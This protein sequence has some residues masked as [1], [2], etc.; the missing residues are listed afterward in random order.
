MNFDTYGFD[1]YKEQSVRVAVDLVNTWDLIADVDGLTTVEELE[2]F[3]TRH[4]GAWKGS[5]LTF[6]QP[7]ARDL[8]A[9]RR[10]REEIR[11]VFG[12]DN[13]DKA[14]TLINAILAN[15]GA[16]PRIGI[17]AKAPHLYF[18]TRSENLAHQLAAT[19]ALGLT[20][21]LV[22]GGIDRFGVCCS[23]ACVDVFVD[24]SKNNS[25]RH[26]STTC[27]N[28]QNVAAHRERIRAMKEA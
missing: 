18:E 15:A 17:Y 9:V 20:D 26:C 12:S 1:A 21:V 7:S 11:E 22:E 8:K 4:E 13:E 27:S 10:L 5:E 24:T 19:A 16:A 6:D 28:R 14:A 3:L 2:R 25:R 23:K